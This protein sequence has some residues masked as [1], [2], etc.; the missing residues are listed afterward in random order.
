MDT[1][2]VLDPRRRTCSRLRSSNVLEGRNE[3]VVELLASCLGRWLDLLNEVVE[4]LGT[5]VIVDESE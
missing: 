2:D 4:M 5:P 3:L 1:G